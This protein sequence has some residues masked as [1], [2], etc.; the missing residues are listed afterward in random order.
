MNRDAN[1]TRLLRNIWPLFAMLAAFWIVC[2]MLW[3]FVGGKFFGSSD[4]NSY[5]LQ[6][7]A[8]REGSL[9]LGR[10]YP[11]LELAIYNDDWY[12]SFPP[13][14]SVPM[15]LLTLVCGMNTPDAL[16][17]KLYAMIAMIAIYGILTHRRWNRWHA[18]G[19]ALLMTLGGSMLPLVMDGAVWYQAQT[20]AFMLTTLAAVLMMS[21]KTTIALFLYALAVGCRPFNVCYGPLLMIVWY[22]RRRRRTLKAALRK[23]APGIALGFMVAAAY[24]AYN[25]ARFGNPLEFG[26]NYL[27]EFTR[28]QYGQF[29]LHYLPKNMKRFLIGLPFYRGLDG[30]AVVEGGFSIFLGNPILLLLVVWYLSDLFRRRT[31]LSKNLTMLFFAVHLFLLLLHRTGGGLQI[32]ARYAVDLVPYSLIYLCLSKEKHGMAWWEIVILTTGFILMFI[33]S[34]LV[35]I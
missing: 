12:V 22:L 2:M 13:V 15:Y 27:P 11:H 5:T 7:M 6:A 26:H 35:H 9:S 21:G 4:Y 18:A 3:P 17:V 8:W 30:L 29:S 14:P 1:R 16:M 34:T 25:Y 20:L 24:A 32:G 10:D 31:N 28:S 33:G 23:L 19:M